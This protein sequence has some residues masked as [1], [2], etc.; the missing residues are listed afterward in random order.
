M[1]SINEILKLSVSER[2]LLLEQIWSSIPSE[3][4]SISKIQQQELDKRLE[5]LESG[6]TRF[7]TWDDVKKNLHKK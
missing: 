7:L 6:E 5:R 1:I 2:L 3:K 4:L